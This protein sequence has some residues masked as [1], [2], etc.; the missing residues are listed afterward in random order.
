MFLLLP[1]IM[2][3][4]GFCINQRLFFANLSTILLLAFFGTFITVFSIAMMIIWVQD[5][6]KGSY[7]FPDLTTNEAFLYAT[8]ISA[9]DPVAVVSQ[10]AALRVDP[11]VEI[12]VVGESLVND[13]VSELQ[14]LYTIHHTH[15]TPC[16]IHCR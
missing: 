4:E 15:H 3:R 10:F 6:V 13:A 1:P 5:L 7:S 12:L 11:S 8:I 9:V 16:I 2:L 14:S